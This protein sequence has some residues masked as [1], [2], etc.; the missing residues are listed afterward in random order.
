MGRV[1]WSDVA[2]AKVV[3]DELSPRF[4]IFLRAVVLASRDD[5]I[6]IFEHETMMD[7]QRQVVEM[8]DVGRKTVR[9]LRLHE[10]ILAVEGIE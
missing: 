2:F 5:H 10:R 7:V 8:Q 9:E 6:C 4:T 3:F 1:R